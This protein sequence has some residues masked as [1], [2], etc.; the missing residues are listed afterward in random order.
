LKGQR[1]GKEDFVFASSVT[2]TLISSKESLG[3]ERE[4]RNIWIPRHE[5][6]LPG[7]LCAFPPTDSS[8]WKID[9]QSG[10]H[11]SRFFRLLRKL[12][13]S[14]RKGEGNQYFICFQSEEGAMLG[15]I[16]ESS[17]N[18]ACPDRPGR[19][20]SKTQFQSTI[21]K[22]MAW[23]TVAWHQWLANRPTTQTFQP[24]SPPCRGVGS[25]VYLRDRQ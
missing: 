12:T 15:E 4:D 5:G 18:T 22:A 14:S 23:C 25:W 13:W 19:A 11:L 2:F 21:A 6:Q 1:E 8:P 24:G 20:D 16:L 7:I 10:H 9:P 17:T 3:L